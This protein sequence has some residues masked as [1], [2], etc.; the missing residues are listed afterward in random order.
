LRTLEVDLGVTERLAPLVPRDRLVVA[1]S[2]IGRAPTSSGWRPTPTPS[3]S[4][5]P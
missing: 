4:A 5:P 3:S 1:E 2:G